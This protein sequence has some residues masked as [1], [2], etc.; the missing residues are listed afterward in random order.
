MCA[1]HFVSDRE[2]AREALPSGLLNAR[3]PAREDDDQDRQMV[4]GRHRDL[5]DAIGIV[6]DHLIQ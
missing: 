1:V 4:H 2:R 3:S 5:G 6:V